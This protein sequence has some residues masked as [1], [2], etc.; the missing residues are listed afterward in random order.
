[1]RYSNIFCN[2]VTCTVIKSISTGLFFLGLRDNI[3]SSEVL[4]IMS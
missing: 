2:V 1:M 4:T 3:F